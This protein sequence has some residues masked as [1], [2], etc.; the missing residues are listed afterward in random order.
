MLR[1]DDILAEARSW[2]RT[3]FQWQQSVKGLACDCKGFVWGV[4]RELGLPEADSSYARLMS[5]SSVDLRLLREGLTALFD[6][7]DEMRPA[8]V[9]LLKIGGRPQHLAIYMGGGR[10]MHTARGPGRVMDVPMG[11]VWREATDSVWSW[12]GIDQS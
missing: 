9:L 1:R 12:R 5:Y 7:A 6:K 10:M 3:P 2:D 8:D 4:A 11:N